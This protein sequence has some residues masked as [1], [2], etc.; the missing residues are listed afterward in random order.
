MPKR[1]DKN[2]AEIIQAFVEKH[3]EDMHTCVPAIVQKYDS[4]VIDAQIAVNW[5]D[6]EG[7]IIAPPILTD[8]PVLFPYSLNGGI[9][10]KLQ[11]GDNVL[12]VVSEYSIDNFIYGS[13]QTTNA[14][15]PR[16]FNL[17]DAF[18]FAGVFT[19]ARNPHDNE[20]ALNI[21]YYGNNIKLKATGDI[22]ISNGSNEISMDSAGNINLGKATQKLVNGSF[23]TLF[24]THTH[25]SAGSPPATPMTSVN[26]TKRSSAE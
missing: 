25:P 1:R 24:N 20:D 11:P 4:G 8:V 22:K 13:G 23:M 16:K 6:D 7:N 21:D 15:D 19:F 17:S 18:A 12:V 3:L 9:R 14:E 2:L 10:W 5:E 26:F